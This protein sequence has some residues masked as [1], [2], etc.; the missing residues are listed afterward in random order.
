VNS[1]DVW[2]QQKAIAPT[3]SDKGDKA[4]KT[5]KIALPSESGAF[6]KEIAVPY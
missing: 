1:T 3:H 6:P 4:S 2:R 5:P